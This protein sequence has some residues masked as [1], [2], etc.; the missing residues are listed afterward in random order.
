MRL[1]RSVSHLALLVFATALGLA[2]CPGAQVKTSAPSGDVDVVLRRIDIVKA[3][4]DAMEL[5]I[6]VA[7]ENG[8]DSDVDISAEANIALV[9]EASTTN[10]G[11]EP[12]DAEEGDDSGEGSNSLDDDDDDGDDDGAAASGLDGKRY[13]GTGG[14]SAPPNAIS[15]LP[16]FVTLP[17]PK[18]Q[19]TLEEVLSWNKGRIHIAG[20][21]KA[22]M[23]ERTIGGEREVALPKLPKMQLKAAQVAKMDGGTAGEAFITLLLENLNPFEVV[24]DSVTWRILIADK[25]LKTKDDG[26][27]SL[28]PSSVEEYNVSVNL[29]ESAFP[30]DEL[31]KLLNQPTIS[32]RVDTAYDV[33]GMKKSDIFSG[34]MKFPR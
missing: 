12:A 34:E 14:G 19:A 32:Y 24:V 18:D 30:K 13:A 8:T 4:F 17:L 16:I 25:E 29:N 2:A 27:T 33:D 3:G 5:K 15:E 23:T 20:K 26:G 7:V 1:F 9:G 11:D 21:V 31:K 6:I 10:D 28:P 22:G